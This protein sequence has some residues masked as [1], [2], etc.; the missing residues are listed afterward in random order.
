MNC[1]NCK[2]NNLSFIDSYKIE[3]DTD[4]KYLGEMNIYR[5]KDCEISFCD[6]MPSLEK[7]EYFYSKIYRANN[8][9]HHYDHYYKKNSFLDSINLDYLSYLTTFIDFSKV[10][11]VFDF[12]AGL[13]NLGFILKKNFSHIDL[14]C[15]ENDENCLQTLKDRG[16]TNYNKLDDINKKF[17]LVISLHCFEH[18]TN[19]NLINNLKSLI[20]SNGFLFVEVPNAD[21]TQGYKKRIFDSPHLLFFN[22]KSI[23]N[24]FLDM[25]LKITNLIH[26]SYSMDYDFDIQHKSKMLF[27]NLSFYRKIRPYFKNLAPNFISSIIK[28]IRKFRNLNNPDII[29]WHVNGQ[30]NSR[31]IRGIFSNR[32]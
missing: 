5:C 12:G 2:K 23:E 24:I 27:N 17:D 14:Y 22:K 28:N 4:V 26:S 31:F 6:P 20:N 15:C 13:G 32:N 9:P 21:F 8:R 11:T 25:N 16:Y 18:L 10:K 29:K 1:I 19:I 7:L 3:I 30:K